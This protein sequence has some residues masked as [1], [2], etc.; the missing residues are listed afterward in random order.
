MSVGRRW[1][2]A[3]RRHRGPRVSSLACS[4]R[5]RGSMPSQL[6]SAHHLPRSTLPSPSSAGQELE[7]S[8]APSRPAGRRPASSTEGP[9]SV[10]S[11]AGGQPPR[12]CCCTAK[13]GLRHGGVVLERRR[14]PRRRVRG[15]Q[16]R[17]GSGAPEPR[18]RWVSEAEGSPAWE[19]RRALPVGTVTTLAR[20]GPSS[21]FF[22]KCLL[23]NVSI[24]PGGGC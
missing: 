2:E 19:R 17:A 11:M 10:A 21:P 5:S 22:P 4:G 1:E 3:R 9:S 13:R 24:V 8:P 23:K 15:K 14:G 18:R 12:R 16:E 20:R 7:A 6:S